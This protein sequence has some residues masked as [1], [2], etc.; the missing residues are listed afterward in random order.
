M[1]LLQASIPQDLHGTD[2]TSVKLQ[3]SGTNGVPILSAPPPRFAPF[4]L[5]NK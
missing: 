5:I 1:T 3:L 4:L 2:L